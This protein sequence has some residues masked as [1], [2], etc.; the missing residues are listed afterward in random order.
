MRQRLTAVVNEM[1]GEREQRKSTLQSKLE[2][3]SGSAKLLCSKLARGLEEL[4]S[5]WQHNLFTC[6]P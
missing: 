2:I 3:G 4:K 1:S 6:R 5:Q